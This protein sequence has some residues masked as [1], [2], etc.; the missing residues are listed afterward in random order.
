[1]ETRQSK[2]KG[3]NG[4]NPGD[5]GSDKRSA[6]LRD[7][8]SLAGVSVTTA[9]RALSTPELV[10][11]TTM[12][13]I[14]AAVRQL[15]Y[16]P[17]SAARAL[18]SRRTKLIGT[19]VTTLDHAIC[20]SLVETLQAKLHAGGY[21][22]VVT[23]SEFDLGAELEQARILVERGVQA[24][25]L[26]GDEHSPK[27]YELMERNRI[28]FV[29]TYVFKPDRPY[30]CVGFDN[31]LAGEQI[32]SHLVQ[33][34]HQHIAMIAG[35]QK[36]NDRARD[37]AAGVKRELSR[38]GLNLR[39]EL[40]C[41][42]KYN[43]DAGREGLRQLLRSGLPISAVICGSDVLAFGVLA[44]CRSLK[45][46]VP[47]ELSITGFD[48]LEFAPHLDPPLT[49]IRVPAEEMGTR[50]AEYVI[51]CLESEA[52]VQHTHLEATL[53]LRGTTA[54]PQPSN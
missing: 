12:V 31:A 49:T 29:N 19:I 36:E 30:S 54:P 10:S 45:I 18:R 28:P 53:I 20:A 22:L 2:A 4:A 35:I 3:R 11:E 21:S 34:G 16:M 52:N 15:G 9:S 25:V 5:D 26:L 41:E 47:E 24:L 8:A 40:F 7:V 43:I 17:N 44:E 27:L 14:R 51:E 38:C 50:A 48:D 33:L 39:S 6:G 37:R 13:R 46:K 23:S 42:K 1:M 32:A